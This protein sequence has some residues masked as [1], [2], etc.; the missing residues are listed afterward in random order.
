VSELPEP[1]IDKDRLGAWASLRAYL[2][3]GLLVLGPTALSIWI[4]VRIF[5]W[6]DGLLGE[7]L[8]FPWFE[9]RRMPGLGLVAMILLLV[10]VGWIAHLLAGVAVVKAWDRALARVPLFRFVYTPA[11]R[12]GEAFL[13]GRRDAFRQV[14][15]LPW[16]H[17]GTWAIGF[18]TGVPPRAFSDR[19]GDELVS[20]FVPHTPN[21]TSG[22]YQMVPR[23]H[24]VPLD[25]TI[26]QGIQMVASGGLVRPSDAEAAVLPKAAVPPPV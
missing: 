2:L 14:V 18:V 24:L 13:S 5:Y 23:G 16:P 17:S 10:T 1:S 19:V 22:H 21:P 20:V 25:L 12:L 4:L 15:L 3:G 11:K 6:V 26:E 9:Y 7:Y 8:R